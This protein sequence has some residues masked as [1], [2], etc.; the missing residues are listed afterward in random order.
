[1]P[2]RGALPVRI[3]PAGTSFMHAVLNHCWSVCGALALGSQTKSA[4][5]V[6]PLPAP[7]I[8]R[9]AGSVPNELELGLTLHRP[10]ATERIPDVCQPPSVY[11]RKPLLLRKIGSS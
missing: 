1:M 2:L 10:L 9:P 11:F 7:R 4:R 5:G 8:P 6:A 3:S